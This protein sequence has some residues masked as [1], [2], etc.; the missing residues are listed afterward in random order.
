MIIYTSATSGTANGTDG[1]Y[2]P[3]FKLFSVLNSGCTVQSPGNGNLQLLSMTYT[4][5]TGLS[6]T[7]CTFTMPNTIENGAGANSGNKRLQN[8]PNVTIANLSS[9]ASTNGGKVQL[10]VSG[11]FQIVTVDGLNGAADNYI[12]MNF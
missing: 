7:V 4:T 10:Q 11:N 9:G 5:G 8:A 6:A 2:I 12:K 3:A 1:A